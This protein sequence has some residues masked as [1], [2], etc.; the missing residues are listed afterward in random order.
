MLLTAGVY[1]FFKTSTG[2]LSDPN[3]RSALVQSVDVPKI[4]T[5]L[6]YK[7]NAV[8]EPL[9]Q[10]Q[11]GY[12]STFK[13][14]GYN[15]QNAQNILTS[16]G[17]NVSKNGLRV[18]GNQT[19]SFTLTVLHNHEYIKVAKLLQ[20]YWNKIGVKVNLQ[21]LDP[22]SMST[23]LFT[24]DY[25]ALLYGIQIGTDPD[26]FVYWDSQQANIQSQ[27]RLNL[28]EYS[29]PIADEALKEGRT[30]LNPAIRAIKY[31]GFL[32]VWQED[33]PALGLYQPRDLYIT[34]GPVYNLNRSVINSTSGRLDNVSNWEINQAMVTD[35]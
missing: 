25:N 29:N 2:I 15:Y 6:G 9:L 19:L 26:V 11:L 17:W 24:H 20:S 5:S 1:V 3:V 31:E 22:T 16:D 4:I 30:K 34:K 32:K 35:N 21:I 27:T 23:A 12:N 13:E 7:T 8:N 33:L 28:S 14:P 18:K 10:G